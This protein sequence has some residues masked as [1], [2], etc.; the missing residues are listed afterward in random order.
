MDGRKGK[1]GGLDKKTEPD[2]FTNNKIFTA[3]AVAEAR[4][5]ADEILEISPNPTFFKKRNA[6]ILIRQLT[7]IFSP[8]IFTV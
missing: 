7:P 5:I 1:S 8:D 2:K 4:K 3:D 6:T